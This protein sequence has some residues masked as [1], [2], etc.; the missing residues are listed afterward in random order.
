MGPSPWPSWNTQSLGI[1]TKGTSIHTYIQHPHFFRRI[2][3][4]QWL[5]DSDSDNEEED[6]D[7][8]VRRSSKRLM[9]LRNQAEL[10]PLDVLQARRRG[11]KD[12]MS[13]L[14]FKLGQQLLYGPFTHLTLHNLPYM[15]VNYKYRVRT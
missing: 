3:Y 7:E 10:I 1:S 5:R 8:D 4:C 6:E 13:R 2:R 15:G 9:I 12:G 14:N 11:E